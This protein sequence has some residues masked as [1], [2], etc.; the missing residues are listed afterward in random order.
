MQRP[1]KPCTPVRFRLQPPEIM[2]KIVITGAAGFIGFHLSKEFISKGYLVIGIDNLNEYY[3][4]ALK[5][6]RLRALNNE[7][8]IFHEA[9]IHDF[10][11][12]KD[13]FIKHSPEI[14]VNLA[15][16][17]G[18]RY[19]LQNP[20][21]YID[22]NIIGFHNLLEC[23][24]L[25]SPQRII[26]ASSSSVYGDN[27][28]VP[29]SESDTTDQTISLYAATKKANEQLAYSFSHNFKIPTIGLRF[30]TVYGPMGRPDMAYYSFTENLINEK[31]IVIFNGGKMSRDMT[32]I[33]DI[34]SGILSSVDIKVSKSES[35]IYNLGNSEPVPLS[36]LINFIEN[37]CSK[38]FI[39]EFQEIGTEVKTTFAD[40]SKSHHDLGYSPNTNFEKGMENFLEWYFSYREI[41]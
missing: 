36:K 37:Y 15:A 14:V 27:R 32:Y 34:V 29:F 4:K 39:K 38:K 24:R 28:K 3:D 30:F 5:E 1:A 35:R 31:P 20:N 8:F 9:S 17:A 18:V 13:I 22:S 11:S 7:N 41:K 16:Q 6:Y 2:K 10:E 19:S 33:D 23:C 25:T 40:L 12:L 26:Y 21:S